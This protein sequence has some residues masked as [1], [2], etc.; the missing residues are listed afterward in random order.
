M[1]LAIH[2]IIGSKAA[3]STPSIA[4]SGL[5]LYIDP[6]IAAPSG[7]TIYDVT[8]GLPVSC[9]TIANSGG[10]Y[11]TDFGGIFKLNGNDQWLK[12]FGYRVSF[13]AGFTLQIVMRK[14]N[15]GGGF[16]IPSTIAGNFQPPYQ[17]KIYD[18]ALGNQKFFFEADYGYNMMPLS[19]DTTDWCMYTFISSNANNST[20][21]LYKNNEPT[22]YSIPDKSVQ[23]GYYDYFVIGNFQDAGGYSFK[24]DIGA[25]AFYGREL[26]TTEI[27]QNFDVFKTRFGI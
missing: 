24:G 15:A 2:G 1:I 14:S 18:S 5:N 10:V 23:S 9:G 4:K 16:K 19:S 13:S 12:L 7:S 26:N 11:S 25:F 17:F 3:A 22:N 20:V 8:S 6:S 21:S 27:S